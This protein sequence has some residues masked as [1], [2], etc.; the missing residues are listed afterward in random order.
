MEMENAPG[1]G[2]RTE[3]SIGTGS[4]SS[5][6]PV[7]ALS[8]PPTQTDASDV[9]TE[10]KQEKSFSPDQMRVISNNAK[11]AG[12]KEEREKWQKIISEQ[13]SPKTPPQTPQ[14]TNTNSD[15]IPI[16]VASANGI[17]EDELYQKF[18][19][20][21]Q[22]EQETARLQEQAA[23][24]LSK[25]Q[26]NGLGDKLISSG[27]GKLT[28]DHPLI[29]MLNTL[30]NL[31]DI[32]D[33]LDTHPSKLGN[34]ITAVYLNPT[35]AM[36]ELSELSASLRKNREALERAKNKAPPPPDQMKPTTNYGLSSG[37]QTIADK[38]KNKLF[39]F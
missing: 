11:T 21:Q 34:L 13:Y 28:T 2:T 23:S 7:P 22:Q 30:E 24:F 1:T 9:A 27:L 8:L 25:I 31:P 15:Q 10:T 36:S 3:S 29:P 26:V 12:I 16:S 37:E 32:I 33:D 18:Q 17:S 38:R 19:Q 4:T 6:I 14:Q 20:R 39:K 35:R 5:S